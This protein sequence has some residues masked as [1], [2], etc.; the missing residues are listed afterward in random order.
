MS[1]FIVIGFETVTEADETLARLK[2]LQREYLIDL[3]DAVIATRSPEGAVDLKQ[4]VNLVGMG[5]ASSGVSGAMFGT[6]IGLLFL[7]PLAGMAIGG[8]IGAGTGALAGSLADYG[9]NDD[10]IR[11]IA[12]TLTP[13]SSALFL[14]V[15]KAQPEKVMAEFP[16]SKGRIIRSSLSPEAEE[17]LR[18]AIAGL[19]AA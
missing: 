2:R 9:I 4:S 1:E 18:E 3:E 12:G 17:K 6:L 15:R 14:L 13:G 11:E 10:L 5:A 8:A 7:N 16:H 19:N